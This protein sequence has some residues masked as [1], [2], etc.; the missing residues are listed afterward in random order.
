MSC[1]GDVPEC[2]T[3]Y[4]ISMFVVAMIFAQSKVASDELMNVNWND[5]CNS[6]ELR[7]NAMNSKEETIFKIKINNNKNIEVKKR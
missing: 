4:Y 3:N 5:E 2:H 1:E 6:K 7:L